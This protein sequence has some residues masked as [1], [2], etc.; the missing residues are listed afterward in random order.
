MPETL[1]TQAL[2]AA[3]IAANDAA[4]AAEPGDDV[5]SCNF[6][7]CTIRLPHRL[8]AQVEEAAKGTGMRARAE[9]WIG[10]C[11]F[12]SASVSGGQ[13]FSRTR[14]AEAIRDALRGR[15]FDALVY[16]QMD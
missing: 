8:K 3:F 4:I 1:D 11:F 10:Q 12:L 9:D 2:R 15:G 7:T 6:D 13:G 16:Y 5:G 14:I